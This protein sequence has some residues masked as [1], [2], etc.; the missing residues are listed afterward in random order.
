MNPSRKLLLRFFFLLATLYLILFLAEFFFLRDIIIAGSERN[1][2]RV[3]TKSE[4]RWMAGAGPDTYANIR[5]FLFP[6]ILFKYLMMLVDF[7]ICHRTFWKKDALPFLR[8]WWFLPAAGIA[9]FL[10]YAYY[11]YR[12]ISVY[13]LYMSL[14]PVGIFTLTVAALVFLR[15][16]ST[17]APCNDT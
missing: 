13:R 14:I 3:M 7:I 5:R 6:T 17:G 12:R 16:R 10:F 1:P 2:F 4:I 9:L 15:Q 11:M 8:K